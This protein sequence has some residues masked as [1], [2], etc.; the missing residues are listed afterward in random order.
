[1]TGGAEAMA[2]VQAARKTASS[3][4]VSSLAPALPLSRPGKIIC[5]G[6]NYAD[7]AKEGGHDVPDYPALFMRGATT[8]VPAEGP[9][10]RPDCSERLDY[11]V[12]LMVIIGKGGRHISEAD[13]LSHIFGYSVFNDVSSSGLPT[14]DASVD[15]RQKLRQHGAT[16][17]LRRHPG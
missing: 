12:E 13:A 7:H 15:T 17:T 5:L 6:L 2:K 11:E 14:Q 8:L 1:M 9:V 16:G 10:V 4:P 3:V